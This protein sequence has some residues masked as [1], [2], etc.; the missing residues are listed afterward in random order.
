VSQKESLEKH[1][2]HIMHAIKNNF[3][4]ID[5]EDSS[6]DEYDVTM[7]GKWTC[8]ICTCDNTLDLKLCNACDAPRVEK[9]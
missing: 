7:Q 4:D 1:F 6:G 2:K 8:R 9:K 5:G 3:P